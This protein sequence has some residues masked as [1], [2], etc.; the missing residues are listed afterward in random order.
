MLD[1]TKPTVV[2][3]TGSVREH[4][5]VANVLES[6]VGL[7]AVFIEA[8]RSPNG[9]WRNLRRLYRK[10]GVIKFPERLLLRAWRKITNERR[11][12]DRQLR[13]VLGENSDAFDPG[14]PLR[15][16]EDLNGPETHEALR[17]LSPDV[18]L[19][20]G[21]KLIRD[22]ILAIAKIGALNMHTGISPHY[23]GSDCAFWPVHDQRFDMLGATV[24]ECTSA[25]DGG[26]I[27][28]TVRAQLDPADDLHAIF[29]RC[30]AAGALLYP[31]CVEQVLKR[32]EVAGIVQPANVG[33]EYRSGMRGIR[34]EW[35]ARRTLSSGA[36]RL[37][38]HGR[39]A[40]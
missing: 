10:Y 31:T 3:L 33:S 36:L 32:G 2:L 29:A 28:G 7:S 13:R 26:A 35:N 16:V 27:L 9:F 17:S 11:R 30:V 38:L 8:P 12:R 24:H 5:H 18:V 39:E 15:E 22:S 6:Q 25:V 34:A 14:I 4:R 40:L 23:R 21:T 37:H 19:V 20:Y 1:E